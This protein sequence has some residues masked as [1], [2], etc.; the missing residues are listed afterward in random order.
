MSTRSVGSVS[1][2]SDCVDASTPLTAHTSSV[3]PDAK[4]SRATA[5]TPSPVASTNSP[6]GDGAITNT[7]LASMISSR[8]DAIMAGQAEANHELRRLADTQ[9]A[10]QT[11][12]VEVKNDVEVAKQAVSANSTRLTSVEEEVQWLND[13]L[14]RR[15]RANDLVLRNVPLVG[16]ETDADHRTIVLKVAGA[17]GCNLAHESLVYVEARGVKRGANDSRT[18]KGVLVVGLA[19]QV[20]Y[21]DFFGKFLRQK[22]VDAKCIGFTP[23][24]RIFIS[25]NMTKRNSDIRRHAL[26]LR[27]DNKIHLFS[28]RDGCVHVTVR[29]GEQRQLV[30]SIAELD[31][32]LDAQRSRRARSTSS[33]NLN[34]LSLRQ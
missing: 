3:Q 25:H 8:F 19:T 20:A 22:F 6:E 34:N 9:A 4:R 13:G 26:E 10:L 15:E 30:R 2:R 12:L 27:A 24:H 7:V 33:I 1:G 5:I 11:S 31:S 18:T 21:R 28:V 23:G 29:Q 14:Q 16:T 17:V 32:L